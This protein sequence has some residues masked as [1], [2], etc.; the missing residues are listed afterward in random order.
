VGVVLEVKDDWGGDAGAPSSIRSGTSCWGLNIL[1]LDWS[2][3]AV[4]H[5]KT[6]LRDYKE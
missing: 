2:I 6:G 4:A 1:G 5:W 3:R